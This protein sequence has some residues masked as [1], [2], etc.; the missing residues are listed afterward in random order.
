M[1]K[2]VMLNRVSIDGFFASSNQKTWGMDWFVQDPEV[3]KAVHEGE[4]SGTLL[5]GR[6][7][8]TG[9]ERSWVPQLKDP[10][11]P[12][13][14]KAVA[15]ELTK[16]TKVV[17]S[18]TLKKN[19]ITWENTELFKGNL[20]ERVRKLKQEKGSDMLIMGSGTIVQQLANAGLIDDYLVILTPVIAGEGKSLFKAVKQFKLKLLETKSFDSGNVL[21]RYAIGKLEK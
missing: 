3:D 13:A 14:M 21:L 1:R 17:F 15:E 9:F 12:K 6:K 18:K 19:E 2:V 8:Y 5:L 4:D 16:M 10:N 7:T 11:A 20:L